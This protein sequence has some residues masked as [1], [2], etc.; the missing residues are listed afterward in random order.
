M[1]TAR[2]SPEHFGTVLALLEPWEGHMEV[3]RRI[4]AVLLDWELLSY[5]QGRPAPT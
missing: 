1:S 4:H 3:N 5:D 2:L